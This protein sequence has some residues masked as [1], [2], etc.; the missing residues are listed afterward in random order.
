MEYVSVPLDITMMLPMSVKD[1]KLHVMNVRANP[2]V[3]NV[4]VITISLVENVSY[5]NNAKK[6]N[7]SINKTVFLAP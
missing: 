5:R 2:N 3:P 1:V 4:K 6:D 7:S